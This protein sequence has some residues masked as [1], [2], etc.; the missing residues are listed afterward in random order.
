[1]G[2]LEAARPAII[3]CTTD[4]ARAA[5]FYRDTLGLAVAYEDN[6]AAVF[7]LGGVTLRVSVVDGFTPHEHT[8]LGFQV[9]DVAAAVRALR[10]K[11]VTFNIYPNFRQDELGILTVP[12]GAVHVAWFQDPD[13][14]VL[15]VTN[16]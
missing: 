6:L 2:I 4:R 9:P 5:A 16:A 11:G 10:E 7:H 15:S 1:M 12:G 13:G 3:I 8:I 14:N